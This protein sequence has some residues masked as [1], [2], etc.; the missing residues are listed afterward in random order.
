VETE[1]FNGRRDFK[2]KKSIKMNLILGGGIA[3]ISAAYH[4]QENGHEYKLCEKNDS[5]GGL[6]DNFIINGFLFIFTIRYHTTIIKE[7][8]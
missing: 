3:G 1:K 6:C 7:H 2:N 8:G 4:L 5:W